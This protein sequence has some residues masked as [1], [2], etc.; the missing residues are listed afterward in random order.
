MLF[1]GKAKAP[2]IRTLV[3]EGTRVEGEIRFVEG[4]RIDGHVQGDLLAQGSEAS[5]VVVSDRASVH[6]GI[7]AGHVIISG[8]VHGPVHAHQLLELQAKARIV[9]DVRYGALEM[10]QGATISGDLKPLEVDEPASRPSVAS[11][12]KARDVPA[13]SGDEEAIPDM[14][15]TSRPRSPA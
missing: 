3:G 14:A 2:T 10:H 6:G 8:E 5:L 12:A 15:E 4:L 13:A 1:A 7:H 9:G 11:D